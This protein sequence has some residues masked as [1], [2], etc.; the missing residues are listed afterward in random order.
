MNLLLS[1]IQGIALQTYNGDNL[2][3]LKAALCSQTRNRWS[4]W[5]KAA[6]VV[7]YAPQTSRHHHRRFSNIH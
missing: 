7:Y 1:D 4:Y 2:R 3:Y 6:Q 5:E